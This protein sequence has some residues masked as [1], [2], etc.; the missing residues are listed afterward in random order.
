VPF[1]DGLKALFPVSG[2]RGK[3]AQDMRIERFLH[4]LVSVARDEHPKVAAAEEERKRLEEERLKRLTKRRIKA[5]QGVPKEERIMP[6]SEEEKRCLLSEEEQEQITAAADE[7]LK[8][9]QR[10]GIPPIL[11]RT[12]VTWARRLF[13]EHVAKVHTDVLKKRNQA[14]KRRVQKNFPEVA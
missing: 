4:F 6:L 7:C 14:R 13:G 8:K 2:N 1:N 5:G 9:M 3:R 12:A 10:T 11:F